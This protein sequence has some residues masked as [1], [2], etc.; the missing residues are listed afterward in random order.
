MAQVKDIKKCAGCPLQRLYPE[1]NFVP[2]RMG[3]GL[4]LMIA[5]CPG[6]T[7]SR[8]LTPLVGTSGRWLRGG[9]DPE[10]GRHHGGLLKQANIRDEDVTYGNCLSCRPPNNVFPDSSEARTYISESDAN[11]AIGQC[12]K[13]HVLP[14]LLSRPWLRLDLLGEKALRY[15]GG[16]LGGITRWRGSPIEIDTEDVEKRADALLK[17]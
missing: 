2:P 13:N 12:L 11:K 16:K 8:E 10:T 6:E 5:E 17:G 3:K 1:S 14:L 7:E 4:R 15:V 9:M